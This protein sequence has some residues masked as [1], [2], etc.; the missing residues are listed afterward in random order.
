MA[1]NLN[2]NWYATE[3][4]AGDML[5][6]TQTISVTTAPE[7]PA[8]WM[9]PG[10]MVEGNNASIWVLVKASATVT[11]G[12]I[13][14]FDVNY[15]AVDATQTLLA[16]LSYNVGIAQFGPGTIT[17]SSSQSV[18]G[19]GD[20]FWAC[21]Q[22]AGGLQINCIGSCL[23][24]TQLYIS[25]TTAGSVTSS[26]STVQVGNL[27]ANTSFAGTGSNTTTDFFAVG[28]VRGVTL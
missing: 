18:A 10:T 23:R 11:S 25:G 16:S 15:N 22:A 3:P 17:T 19:V 24:G 20:Y 9:A 6:F 13:V 21:L 2:R 27:Y 28:Q 8:P 1:Q 12:N 4:V 7:T 14:V 26:V 5:N